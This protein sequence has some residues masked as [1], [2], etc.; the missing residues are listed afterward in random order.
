MIHSVLLAILGFSQ[1]HNPVTGPLPPD[2][3]LDAGA[4]GYGQAGNALLIR[5]GYAC[6]VSSKYKDPLWSQEHLTAKDLAPP[7]Q[8]RPKPDPFKADPNLSAIFKAV[9]ADYK[10]SGFDRGHMSPSGDFG[11]K[12][13]TNSNPQFVQIESF[14][15]SNMVPQ[16]GKLNRGLW[17]HFEAE[18]RRRVPSYGEVQIITGPVF[19]TKP[20]KTIGK[21]RVAVPDFIYKIV[22]VTAPGAHRGTWY[23]VKVPN[24]DPG[25]KPISS[26]VTTIGKI[27]KDTGLKFFT[28][29]SVADKKKLDD[30]TW[31]KIPIAATFK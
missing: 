14:Y 6:L 9:L 12:S 7:Q 21:G 19:K 10:G 23:A 11:R 27:E 31:P 13:L 2:L 30:G 4:P 29:W 24:A 28:S 16:N 8:K 17:A 18:I 5:E 15:L 25:K 22:V 26:F 3:N 20:V 1:I